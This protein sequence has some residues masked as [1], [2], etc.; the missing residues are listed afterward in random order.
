[1][2]EIRRIVNLAARAVAGKVGYP[3]AGRIEDYE[4][5]I[6][7]ALAALAA[8]G[9]VVVK[10]PE[11]VAVAHGARLVASVL[12]AHPV[13]YRIHEAVPEVEP[14][15]VYV[16]SEADRAHVNAVASHVCNCARCNARRRP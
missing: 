3:G 5:D 8:E 6:C 13:L 11:G 9:Y 10:V 7:V 1:M 14:E 16:A 2:G 12:P 15:A 4:E